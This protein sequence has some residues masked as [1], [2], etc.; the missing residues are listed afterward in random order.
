MKKSSTDGVMTWNF[1]RM[2][3]ANLF[4]FAAV[5]LLFPA[6]PFAMGGQ[7]GIPVSQAGN[8][9]LAFAVGLFLVGPFHAWLGDECKR[10]HVLLFS[11]AGMLVTT[12]GYLVIASYVQ[13]L[14]LALVQGA[15]FGLAVTA[16]I[17]V[18][19]DIILSHRRTTANMVYAW[20]ARLGMLLGVGAGLL[21]YRLY[22]FHAVICLS[23][24]CGVLSLLSASGVY[25]AFRAPIGVPLCNLDRFLLPRA[26]VMAIDALLVTLVSGF[27]LPLLFMGSCYPAVAL[28]AWA[29]LAA[30]FTKLFVDLSHHCQRGTANTTCHLAME[31]GLLIGLAVTCHL[32]DVHTVYKAAILCSV[33]AILFFLLLAYPYYKRK[34]VR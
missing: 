32:M 28:G 2:C 7:L 9:F 4:L 17:T 23:V 15:C 22:D 33:A 11:T 18:A 21:V 26:W 34:R 31:S 25:V 8:L 30:P 1:G 6:L 5:Y 20:V 19:I 12:A 14:L 29:L 3:A 10:K 24:A 27:L 16:G 13:L